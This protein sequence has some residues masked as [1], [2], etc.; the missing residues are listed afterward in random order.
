MA[1]HSSILDWRIPWTEEPGGLQS[2]RSQELDM[3]ER[4]S[5]NRAMAFHGTS[6]AAQRAVWKPGHRGWCGERAIGPSRHESTATSCE[7]RY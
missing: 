4:L 7:A 1:A 3:T 5:N 2:L 6:A